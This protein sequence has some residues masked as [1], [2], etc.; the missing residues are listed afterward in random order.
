MEI[1]VYE[2]GGGVRDSLLGVPSKD[3]DFVVIAPSFKAMRLH[4]TEQGLRV[5]LEKEEFAT[6]RCGVPR[7]HPLR[8]RTSAADFVLARRDGPSS[9]G[10]RPD[11]V[12][13]GNLSEDLARRDF[14][15]NALARNP[16]TGDIIDEHGGLKD[17][18]ELR[19]RFVGD[20]AERIRED[21]LRVLRGFRFIITKGLT[22]TPET[23]AALRSDEAASMLSCVSV[24]RIHDELEKMFVHDTLATLALIESL[25]QDMH[26]AIFRS[27]LRLR[28]TLKKR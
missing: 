19:L 20:P 1:R 22:P 17:L 3:V 5:F 8:E 12:E 18:T 26:R 13:A 7:N 9:D 11:F 28:P 16:I 21:G 25:S 23:N 4:L 2:V 27:G 14:T 10:R 6:I 15:V 24:E